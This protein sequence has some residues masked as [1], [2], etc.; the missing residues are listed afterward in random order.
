MRMQRYDLKWEYM[1][2][3]NLVLADALSRSYLPTS[4]RGE[5]E[6]EIETHVRMIMQSRVSDLKKKE[7]A[8]ATESDVILLKVIS[9]LVDGISVSVKPYQDFAD[10]LTVVDGL[11]LRGTR[12]VVPETMR[13]QVLETIHEGHLGIE[14]CKRRARK[15][16]Y[17]PGMNE[18]IK[19]KVARCATCQIY[20]Y[21]QKKEPLMPTTESAAKIPWGMVGVDLFALNGRDYLLINDYCS[22]FPETSLLTSTTS[23]SV[24]LQMKSIFARHGIPLVVRTD[25]GPQFSSVEF[26]EFARGYGFEHQTSSPYYPRSNGMAE[27]GVKTVKSLLKK[28][29]EAKQDPYLALLN[30][31]TTPMQS[32]KSPSDI[33]YNGREVNTRLSAVTKSIVPPLVT[34][35]KSQQQRTQAAYYDRG[36]VEHPPLN[37]GDVV[38]LRKEGV[39][40]KRATVVKGL[41]SPRSYEVKTEQG[42][43]Y[44]RNRQQL[45]PIGETAQD[46][47]D[48]LDLDDIELDEDLNVAEKPDVPLRR[49]GRDKKEPFWM[50]DYVKH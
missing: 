44:R 1:P 3:E 46:A 10:E 5:L 32:G 39:W 41:V 24:I 15:A 21:Q 40:G 16:V 18:A 13:P 37:T 34:H 12:V 43:T 42:Q 47:P 36:T 22:N 48:Q 28:A 45:L 30:Y 8:Q 14:K 49:S 4:E 38:R 19:Q 7:M 50:N 20:Q 31:R 33:L 9:E 6:E 23:T 27:C 26:A 2:G 25:N 17:W 29:I 11:L 35:S